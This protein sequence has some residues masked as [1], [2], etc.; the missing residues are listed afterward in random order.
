MAETDPSAVVERIVTVSPDYRELRELYMALRTPPD[1]PAND[2]QVVT[3]HALAHVLGE[4]IDYLNFVQDE[5]EKSV[6]LTRESERRRILEEL[7][8]PA[9][10]DGLKQVA[11]LVRSWEDVDTVTGDRLRPVER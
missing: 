2:E 5:L 9:V 10:D 11:G 1:G 8:A 7:R 6:G 3:R 4:I